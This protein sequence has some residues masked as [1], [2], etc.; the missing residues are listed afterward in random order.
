MTDSNSPVD[1]IQN[2]LAWSKGCPE[3]QRDALRRLCA[4]PDLA[5]SD[6]I[7]LLEIMKGTRVANTLTDQ[8]IRQPAKAS[9]AIILKS[10]HN[11]ENIN[12]LAEK[13]TLSFCEKGVT[14]VYGDNGSGKSGYAR[15]LKGA[16]RARLE[17][18]FDIFCD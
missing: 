16:C 4:G 3:W 18:G 5:E 13:Q 9:Q 8:Q 12:A 17:R 15:I 6:E 14:I 1:R 7:E 11:A 2:I 10:I